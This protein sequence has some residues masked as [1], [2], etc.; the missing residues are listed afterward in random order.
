MLTKVLPQLQEYLDA[1]CEGFFRLPMPE[2]HH[3]FYNGNGSHDVFMLG[4]LL[5]E[6]YENFD[7]KKD[8]DEDHLNS[9]LECLAQLHGTGLAYKKKA[10]N[11]KSEFDGLEEQIQLNDILE[12]NEIREFFRAHFRAFLHYLEETESSLSNHT[13]YMKKMHKHILNVVGTLQECG[14]EKLITICHGDAKPNNFMFRNISIDLE[15]LECEGLQSILIDWQGGFVG[16]VANDLMWAL[17]PFLEANSD[18]KAAMYKTA[19]EYYFEQLTIV[20]E[21]FNCTLAD[22]NLPENFPEFQSLLKKC[23]VLEFIIVTVIKPIIGIPQPKKLLKWHKETEKNKTRRFKKEVIKPEYNEVFTSPRFA[24]FCHL[25]FKI[26]TALGAFQELGKI[27]FDVMKDSMFD[28]NPEDDFDSDVDS[29]ETEIFYRI[30]NAPIPQMPKIQMPRLA[31]PDFEVMWRRSKYQ[32]R[33]NRYMIAAILS[34]LAATFYMY[35]SI[36]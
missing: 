1:E 35:L 19:L 5:A 17:Y 12:N 24:G 32:M 15:D 2:V 10:G 28:K 31:V 22:L 29:P 34:G 3:C 18:K 9:L 13:S 23:L 30:V 11:L 16:S 27:Y 8:F 6:E 36:F 14:F 33:R 7:E 25:Y 21:S 26:A 4:N 20:L